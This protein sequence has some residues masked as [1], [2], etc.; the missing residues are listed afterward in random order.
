LVQNQDIILALDDEQV[1]LD[2]IEKILGN[3]GYLVKCAIESQI[4]FEIIATKQV[5]LVITD[6]MMPD[7]SGLD[8]LTHVKDTSPHTAVIIA[9][10]YGSMNSAIEALRQGATDYII[11]PFTANEL[12]YS[13]ERTLTYRHLQLER[14]NLLDTLQ[15]RNKQLTQMLAASNRLTRHSS[16]LLQ[17]LD[18]TIIIA[19]DTLELTIAVT[20]LNDEGQWLQTNTGHLP[21]A[22]ANW[23]QAS[24][25]NKQTLSKFFK[26]LPKFSQSYLLKA[27]VS[28]RLSF[29]NQPPPDSSP[30]LVVPLESK[31]G[32]LL[33]TLWVAGVEQP[34]TLERV[35]PIEIFANQIAAAIENAKLFDHQTRQVKVRNTLVHAS[36]RIATILNPQEV[37]NTILEAVLDVLPQVGQ[38]FVY[39]RSHTNSEL[40]INGLTK[41]N[42]KTS[43]SPIEDTFIQQ[44]LQN[45][46]TIYYPKWTQKNQ[47]SPKTL[48]VEPLVFT[49]AAL[50]ALALIGQQPHAFSQDDLQILTML[51]NQAAIALQNAWLYA[52]ARRVDEIEALSEAGQ[53]INRSLDLKETLTTIMSVSRSLT[54]AAVSNIYL[55]QAETHRIESVVT[56]GEDIKLRDADRRHAADIAWQ[57][58]AQQQ[59]ALLTGQSENHQPSGQAKSKSNDRSVVKSW[60][61]VPLVTNKASLGVL[62]VGSNQAN[63]FS[64]NDLRL[65][66][67]VAWHATSAIEK[68]RLYEEVQHRLQ[69][70]AAL[71]AISQS[72]S[73]T[74][75]L[76][77]VLELVTKL[78][79]KT[80]PATT[81]S[82]LYLR[83]PDR[84]TLEL[85]AEIAT[86]TL[87]LPPELETGREK[88]IQR[89]LQQQTTVHTAQNTDDH[90][91]WSIM[92]VPLA[93]NDGII[94]VLSIESPQPNAFLATDETLLK[95]FA[96]HASIAIQNANLFRD[97]SIAYDDLSQ[98]QE[99]IL[100][101][102]S[103]LQALF[104]GITDGLYI[105]NKDLEIVAINRAEAQRLNQLP[106]KLVGCIC[107]ES[108]WAEATPAMTKLVQDTFA[109]GQQGTWA[110]QTNTPNRG[111]FTDRDVQTYPIFDAAKQVRQVIIFAQDVSEKRR[112][113]ASLFRSANMAAVGQLASSIAHQINNPLTVIIA[114]AQIMGMEEDPDAQEYAMLQYIEE[115]GGHIRQ[116]VQNLLDFS[117]QESYEW[118]ETDLA[119]TIDDALILVT[120][121]LRKSNI[122]VE[123][124][125]EE[126]IFIMASA[127]HLKLLWMNL[128]LNAR[129]AIS[130]NVDAGMIKI[131]VAQPDQN[132]EVIVEIIDNGTGISQEQRDHLFHPFFTT[133]TGGKHLGL[134]LFTCQA[135]IEAHH[136]KIGIETT[137][138]G[139]GT[140]VTVTL[141]IEIE[142]DLDFQTDALRQK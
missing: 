26:E 22:W 72:I 34:L 33:G 117:T 88:A 73:N 64:A 50:G 9:T 31:Q 82:V 53:A 36:H 42:N 99:E 103:T 29:K 57:T 28:G 125:I 12:T 81:H 114:N 141:P 16:S 100:R 15:Q 62:Q 74:L 1:I 111:P 47:Q 65:M 136:G 38:A 121:S 58:L 76:S 105:T 13:V 135:I 94:G 89:A 37:A 45:R 102:H 3:Q 19:Q 84:G 40:Y 134:G 115:A 54:G 63:I 93:T 106:E 6:L 71:N 10:A 87:P 138:T 27:E 18:E 83:D 43:T 66:Q 90:C 21:P 67:I 119:K 32:Y 110:S 68:A 79:V 59:P 96:S 24:S 23:L 7:A 51:A 140:T 127:S 5:S 55:Y 97:L 44:A 30:V 11:K 124:E 139:Q 91:T 92:A 56:M 61:T 70:T 133:K 130:T 109:T 2:L 104:N 35:Q 69:Q 112:L 137:P 8:I 25:C 142:T 48:L 95:T 108:L 14:A 113:Q 122:Q 132:K 98:Q 49:G 129:D 101:S 128:L 20:V 17:L 75:E 52:E 60:L 86:Q 41:E 120:H 80:I 4:A 46:Q 131:S 126:D 77:R 39:Y 118:F 123:K 116:I 78:V 107:N 85:E